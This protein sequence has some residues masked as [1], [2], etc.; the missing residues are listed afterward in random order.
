MNIME[1][2]KEFHTKELEDYLKDNGEKLFADME[3]IQAEWREEASV[4][5]FYTRLAS[6]CGCAVSE[7]E[8]LV[9]VVCVT[10]RYIQLVSGR[11]A[12]EC[13]LHRRLQS[14]LKQVQDRGL[15]EGFLDELEVLVADTPLSAKMKQVREEFANSDNASVMSENDR[16]GMLKKATT[17]DELKRVLEVRKGAKHDI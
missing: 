11:A 4:T 15:F 5:A 14:H 13:E 12:R 8:A 17:R 2:L 1:S 16:I 6:A 9:W 7:R 10:G 3:G